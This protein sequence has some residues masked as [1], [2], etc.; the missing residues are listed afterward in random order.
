MKTICC[1]SLPLMEKTAVRV[2]SMEPPGTVMGSDMTRPVVPAAKS[3]GS[4]LVTVMVPK[5]APLPAEARI[6]ALKAPFMRV[7][8]QPG[9]LVLAMALMLVVAVLAEGKIEMLSW[10]SSDPLLFS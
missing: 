3:A 7:V 4:A 10:T 8:M 5:V 2:A 9:V 1:P 6:W